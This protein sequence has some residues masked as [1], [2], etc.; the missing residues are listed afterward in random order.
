MISNFTKR[1]YIFNTFSHELWKVRITLIVYF[2]YL[3]DNR[4]TNFVIFNTYF[5]CCLKQGC[6]RKPKKCLHY[7]ASSDCLNR[8]NTVREGAVRTPTNTKI[9]YM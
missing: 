7:T 5:Y 1:F 4:P 8:Y 6:P 3:N 2:L 9:D